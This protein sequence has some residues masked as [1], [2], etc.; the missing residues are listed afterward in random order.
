MNTINCQSS[1]EERNYVNKT[2]QDV[3]VGHVRTHKHLFSDTNLLQIY[4]EDYIDRL[5][6]FLLQVHETYKK[7]GEI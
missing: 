2:E 5:L 6:Q 7:L 4:P 1:L 3:K